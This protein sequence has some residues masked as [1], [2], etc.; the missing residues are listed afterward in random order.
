LKFLNAIL[1]FILMQTSYGQS[2]LGLSWSE[3]DSYLDNQGK[4]ILTDTLASNRADAAK[5][6]AS[7]FETYLT[8]KSTF[9]K[10]FVTSKFFSILYPAD[11]SFRIITGQHFVND[12]EYRYYG[13]IQYAKGG[14]TA[15][16]DRSYENNEEGTNYD[17][18]RADEWQGA[19]YYKLFDCKIK[20]EPYYLLLGFN[21]Y[22]FFN[23]RKI[24]DVLSF[25]VNGQPIFG[26]DVFLP[27]STD[28][29]DTELRYIFTHSADV[30][31]KLNFDPAENMIVLDHLMQMKAI[32][33]GQ[34]E[35]SVPDGSYEG[36]KYKKGKWQHVSVLA[37][38]SLDNIEVKPILNGDREIN[39][40]GKNKGK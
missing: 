14:Y 31:M 18:L 36:F 13:G 11:S 4:I 17:E 20:S 3:L 37:Q 25:D 22:Q 30:S 10:K 6:I 38:K 5:N 29:G 32:Y 2:P 16:T 23:K 28:N 27:D 19:L 7:A 34:G 33:D 8:D 39:I 26:K 9:S 24:I 15:F 21:G 35:T 40:F 1:A 12:N